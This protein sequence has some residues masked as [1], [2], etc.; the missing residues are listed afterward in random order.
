M[1]SQEFLSRSPEIS[2]TPFDHLKATAAA[3]G[4]DT[5]KRMIGAH[6]GIVGVSA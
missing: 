5:S 2:R 3:Q 1:T 4:Y 6:T